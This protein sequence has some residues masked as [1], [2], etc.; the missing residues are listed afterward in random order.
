MH[1]RGQAIHVD[2]PPVEDLGR[3]EFVMNR[4]LPD[5]VRVYNLS[6]APITLPLWH[7]TS[8]AQ[9]KL[10]SYRFCINRF[11]DPLL[12]RYTAHV[13]QPVDLALLDRCL[14][15]FVGTH[16]FNAFANRVSKT[17]R[18]YQKKTIV[19]LTERTVYSIRLVEEGGGYWRVRAV[20]HGAQHHGQLDPRR[21]GADVI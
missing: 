11:V 17:T 20:S 4:L 9:G 6:L 2:L 21:G 14:Q 3:L 12:R 16:D 13:Y 7:A 1:A 18:D 8:A 5:D 19:F 10:Y 15:T